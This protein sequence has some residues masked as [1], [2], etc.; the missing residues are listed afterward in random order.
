MTTVDFHPDTL[1]ADENAARL[2]AANSPLRQSIQRF[3]RN[4]LAALGL[5]FVV[6]ITAGALLAPLI[7]TTAYDYTVLKDALK[8]PPCADPKGSLPFPDCMFAKYPL[9]TDAIGRDFW[10]R[11]IYGARTSMIV[12]FSVP[13]ITLLIGLPLGAAAGWFGG[14]VD[15]TVLRLVEFMT[16]VPSILLALFLLTLFGHDLQN[17]ILFQGITG[18]VGVCRL[19]RAQF[20]TL[21]E[22]DFVTAARALGMTE[23]SIMIRHVMVNAAGPII[24]MFTLG[25]PGAIFGEAGLSFLGLGVNDPIPSW[26]KMVADSSRFASVYWYLPMIPTACIAVTMLAFSFL[27]DGLRDALDPQ[28]QR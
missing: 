13:T 5:V 10:S 8:F 18:W 17:V 27:G 25:I 3:F 23:W 16:A 2:E 19:G 14:W 7:A 26:G 15:A 12:G 6:V 4:R 11:L 22:R 21:R 1:A 28:G 24:V 20:M 9:G